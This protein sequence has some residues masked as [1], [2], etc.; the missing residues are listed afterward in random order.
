M[1]PIFKNGDT[2]LVSGLLYLFKNPKINDIVA[3]KE[4][5]GKILVKRIKEIKDGKFFACGDNK[6]DSL[7]SKDFGFISKEFIIGKLIYKL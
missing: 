2:I 3:F 5:N 7:D 4:K 1:E 6:K